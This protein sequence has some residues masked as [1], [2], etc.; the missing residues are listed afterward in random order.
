MHRILSWVVVGLFLGNTA[1]AQTLP[2][3]LEATANK[4]VFPGQEFELLLS[5]K[6]EQGNFVKN[7]EVNHEK[8][9]HTIIVSKDLETFAHVHPEQKKDGS[10]A[11]TLN[12]AKTTDVD[13][14]D[15]SHAIPKPGTYFIFSE[16]I[17]L[18]TT[19]PVL[20]FDD[21]LAHG[22]EANI[23]LVPDI[24]SKDKTLKYFKE[25]GEVGQKGD[26][27]KVTLTIN[28]MTGMVHFYFKIEEWMTMGGVGHYMTVSDLQSWL[29]MAGHG[30]LISESGDTSAAKTFRHLHAMAEGGGG[31]HSEGHEHPVTDAEGISGENLE[32]MMMGA[33]VPAAG[34][35]K[36]WGQFKHKDKVLTFPYVIEL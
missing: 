28:K 4:A 2:I 33:D 15:A 11:I 3:L 14:M 1:V 6:D 21:L 20:A 27:Y 32:M 16:L 18:G 13:S 5:Y 17:T 25:T 26:T 19:D 36:L 29:G 10:F 30:I 8:L 22:K 24:F 35:Y 12:S 9:N 31:H 34:V 7:F 23:P